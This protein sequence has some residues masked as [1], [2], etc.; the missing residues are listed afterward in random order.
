MKFRHSVTNW[1]ATYLATHDVGPDQGSDLGI[2]GRNPPKAAA[3][4]AKFG[5]KF[6]C[7]LRWDVII[8]QRRHHNPI[9][10]KQRKTSFLFP[11]DRSLENC[12]VGRELPSSKL[13]LQSTED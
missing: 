13:R 2:E 3:L 6:P 8:A 12:N 4:T 7:N 1:P 5:G 11:E 10:K 9:E